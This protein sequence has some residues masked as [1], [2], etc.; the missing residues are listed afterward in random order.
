MCLYFTSSLIAYSYITYRFGGHEQLED[1]TERMLEVSN[2]KLREIEERVPPFFPPS[3]ESALVLF[4]NNV[5]AYWDPRLLL[6]LLTPGLGVIVVLYSLTLNG[7][8]LGYVVAKG[9]P[10]L[11]IYLSLLIVPHGIFEWPA[12]FLLFGCFILYQGWLLKAVRSL[13][14]GKTVETSWL[15][16]GAFM[17]VLSIG[18][19]FIA[20]WVEAFVTTLFVPEG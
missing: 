7:V 9:A 15:R 12:M 16:D 13:I 17:A 3:V 6:I 20:A 8:V 2:E 18:L 14:K 4:L 1:Y 19:F 5:S 11:G 10:K